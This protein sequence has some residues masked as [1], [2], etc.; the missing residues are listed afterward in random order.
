[1][2]RL[3]TIIL[4]ACMLAGIPATAQA[5]I[6]IN[7]LM[8]SNIDCI[9]DD[10]NEFPDSWVELYNSGTIAVNLADYKLGTKDK[11]SKAWQ[12]PS[13]MLPPKQYLV[14]YC[15]KE[16]NGL[17]TD[18]RLESGKD[19]AVYLFKSGSVCDQVTGMK[20]QPAPN[21][22]YGRQTDGSSTW[23]YMTE[24][25]P[26][27]TNCGTVTKNILG[28]PVFSE[29]GRVVTGS[30]SIKL[31]LSLP[32]GSPSGAE[33]RYTTNGSEPTKT[34]AKYF[35]PITITGNRVIRAKIFCDGYLS[36]RS[37]VHSYIFHPRAVTLPIVSIVTDESYLTDQKKGILVDG[38]YQSDKKNYEFDWRRPINLE[39]FVQAGEDS[40]LNQLCETRVMGGA[41][42]GNKLKSLAVYAN[43]RFGEKRFKYEF[44]PDHRPGITDFKSLALRNSGNDFDG[45]YLRDAVIQINMATHTDLDWQAWRP[46]VIY[47]N[48]KYKGMLNFRERSNE[49]N[50]YTNYD[51]LEDIDMFENW[52]E[53]KEGDW[54]NYNQF[55]A[56]Y[57]DHG[58]T[59]AEYEQWMDCAEFANL[60]IMNLYYNNQD[61]PGNNIVMWRPKAE[62]GRWRFIAKDTDFGL[63]LYGSSA[64]YKTLEWLYTP[65]YDKDRNWGANSY[66]AT[67]LF[68]RLMED[69]DFFN[70]F[71]DR[72]AVYMGDFLN[73]R[74][75]RA[76]WDPM[77]DLVWNELVAHKDVNKPD[78]AGWW[79]NSADQLSGEVNNVRTWIQQRT[80]L[81]YQQL[82]DYYKLG[83]PT[84]LTIDRDMTPE[85]DT[86]VRVTINNVPLSATSFDGKMFTNRTVTLNA[87]AANAKQVTGW[88]ITVT[89]NSGAATTTHIEGTKHTFTMP[90][91]QRIDIK[92]VI[93]DASGILSP[94]ADKAISW[95]MLGTQIALDNVKAGT[96]I[97]LYDMLGRQLFRGT[98]TDGIMLIPT[99]FGH[100]TLILKVG[101][102]CIK[103]Q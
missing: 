72:S 93:G 62:G 77:Q 95:R 88:E 30:A 40:K 39:L 84:P 1:M 50:I 55:Q 27:S 65:D 78:W 79:W 102:Q 60:M 43:K 80:A 18:F 45:L 61:F 100:K 74:G 92:T 31:A 20:K 11:E 54:E 66:D 19:G 4:G 6:V 83:T 32:D 63:G 75:T 36:P 73:E 7:E 68:R 16:E 89:P 23:G 53:L 49:D 52:Y 26:G 35:S 21:I 14:V 96:S 59:M 34:S 10:L 70:L 25:T 67:R 5:Q 13:Q 9:M 85:A 3:N 28:E 24:P 38:N 51:G 58:H 91:C 86:G 98:A 15:D 94:S 2:H 46:A 44:F 33:I 42:R 41:S 69:G 8:Q 22:A 81:Y 17:H 76:V 71:I 97:V 48:G 37:T 101:S 57:N 12:L 82:A 99:G 103:L 64:S 90:A 56:F 47:I 29:K 87:I